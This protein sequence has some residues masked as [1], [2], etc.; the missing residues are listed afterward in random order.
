M[1]EISGKAFWQLVADEVASAVGAMLA[2]YPDATAVVVYRDQEIS[3]HPRGDQF[4]IAGPSN[5]LKTIAAA[6]V[7]KVR[8]HWSYRA[9][10]WCPLA[11]ARAAQPSQGGSCN[12]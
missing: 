5:T 6:D 10:L 2:R 7:E 9:E 8:P 11:A 4:V 12:A 3:M 1:T